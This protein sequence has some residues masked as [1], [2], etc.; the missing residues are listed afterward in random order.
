MGEGFLQI[1]LL[2]SEEDAGL[3]QINVI[4]ERFRIDFHLMKGLFSSHFFFQY[5]ANRVGK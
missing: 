2:K 5:V 4:D 3:R 1:I